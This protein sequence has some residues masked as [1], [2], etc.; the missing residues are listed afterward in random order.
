VRTAATWRR[1]CATATAAALVLLPGC[2]RVPEHA[3][4]VIHSAV[5][6]IGPPPPGGYRLL[7]PY[8]VGDLYGS[9]NTGYFVVPVS[10]GAGGFT[11]DLNRTQRALEAE[12]TPTAFSL[13]F[14][15]ITPADARIARLAPLAL[16]RN[17]IDP[18]GTVQ[19]QG[20]PG[21]PALM[22]LYVDRPALIAGVFSRGGQ[23]IRYDI[24]AAQPGYLWIAGL[25]RGAG[26]TLYTVAPR[27][28][29]PTLTIITQ[30]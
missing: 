12:L 20:A 13:G 28:R 21:G 25:R 19:W 11:L 27:P 18:V 4:W 1:L 26:E 3:D 16:Q 9:A 10:S 30:P 24:R 7:F 17:G 29:H 2:T 6:V 14:L 8:V 23:T 5:E 22:L 15:K